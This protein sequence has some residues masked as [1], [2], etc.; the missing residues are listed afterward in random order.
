MSLKERSWMSL[1]GFEGGFMD[2]FEGGVWV[3]LKED[4]SWV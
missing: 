4:Y 2:E 1:D 3:G